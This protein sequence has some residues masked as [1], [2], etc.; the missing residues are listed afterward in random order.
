MHFM[1]NCQ[2]FSRTITRYSTSFTSTRSAF[3]LV[4]RLVKQEKMAAVKPQPFDYFL[5]LDFEATCQKNERLIPQLTGIVQDMVDGQQHVEDVL[6]DFDAWMVAHSFGDGGQKTS[7]FVTC[8]DWDLK[9][10]LPSQ[11]QY[12]NL[13]VAKYFR[14]WVNI[15]RVFA[16]TMKHYPKRDMMGMLKDLKLEHQGR[17]HSGIDDCKNIARILK[18]L[19]EKGAVINITGRR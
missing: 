1:W 5:V 6:K 4:Y 13:N 17:H 12:F 7:A 9:T 14:R 2:L 11:E 8:G 3:K 19:A 16:D 18:A 10:M 15:K